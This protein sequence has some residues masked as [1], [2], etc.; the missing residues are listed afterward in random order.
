[1]APGRRRK[2]A[3]EILDLKTGE[4]EYYFVFFNRVC[5]VCFPCNKGS[6]SRITEFQ[7]CPVEI[8]N[9]CLK[10]PIAE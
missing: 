5:T 10:A 2:V 1:M 7:K 9:K 3:D 8:K 4:P 6:I